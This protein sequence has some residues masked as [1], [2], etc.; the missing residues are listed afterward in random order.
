MRA[1]IFADCYRLARRWRRAGFRLADIADRQ[2]AE[3][4]EASGGQARAAQETA[5]IERVICLN[6][7]CCG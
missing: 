4:G 5:A 6:W 3:R 7:E 1:Y 2:N